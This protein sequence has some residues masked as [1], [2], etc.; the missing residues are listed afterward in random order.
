MFD[1]LTDGYSVILA[2]YITIGQRERLALS[3]PRIQK[4]ESEQPE[5]LIEVIFHCL[6]FIIGKAV[7]RDLC[8]SFGRNDIQCRVFVGILLYD[9]IFKNQLHDAELILEACCTEGLRVKSAEK[10]IYIN[11]FDL[12]YAH[13]VEIFNRVGGQRFI[14][15]YGLVLQTFIMLALP[16]IGNLVKVLP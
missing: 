10:I 8:F 1:G 15:V 14:A 3:E 2:V 7:A 12:F 4:K 11:G 16:F 6:Y 9:C 13:I 5:L